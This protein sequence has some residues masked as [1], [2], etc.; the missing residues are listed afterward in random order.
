MVRYYKSKEVWSE[1]IGV[2]GCGG[3]YYI[4]EHE[5]LPFTL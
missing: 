5:G 1:T 3:K 2:K 4:D